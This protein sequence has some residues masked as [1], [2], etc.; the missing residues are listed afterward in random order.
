MRDYTLYIRDVIEAMEA[1]EK[2]VKQIDIERF[3]KNDMI[4]SA[5]IRKFEIIGEASKCIPKSIQ[6]RY[7]NVPW[8]EMA[9][10]RDKLIHFYFGVKHELV[11]N[12]IKQVIPEIKPLLKKLLKEEKE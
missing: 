2:F 4:S 7:T 3:K 9:G 8:K 12:T 6:Q 1:I 5:V 10:M 11:W